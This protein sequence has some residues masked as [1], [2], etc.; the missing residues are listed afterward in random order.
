MASLSR[1]R[2]FAAVVMER[3]PLGALELHIVLGFPGD[4][5][6]G[7]RSFH[8]KNLYLTRQTWTLRV[9][10]PQ[11]RAAWWLGNQRSMW[12]PLMAPPASSARA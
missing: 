9:L 6:L 1:G 8:A 7:K 12:L 4:L 3:G 2:T 5:Q 10:R 11:S